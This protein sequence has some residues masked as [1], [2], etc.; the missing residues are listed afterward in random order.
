MDNPY[1]T[2]IKM[3]GVVKSLLPVLVLCGL[4]V[5]QDPTAI[6]DGGFGNGTSSNS[7]VQL[8]IGNGGAGQSGLVGGERG[9]DQLLYRAPPASR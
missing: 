7:T 1:S 3:I 8:R 5:A 9:S 2:R 4:C 6:Y